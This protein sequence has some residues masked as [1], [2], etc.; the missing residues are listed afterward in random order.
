MHAIEVSV[1]SILE[2]DAAEIPEGVEIP[3]QLEV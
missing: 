2:A 3:H 1:M